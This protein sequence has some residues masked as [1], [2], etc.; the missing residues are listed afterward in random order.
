MVW[1]LIETVSKCDREWGF[2]FSLIDISQI[3]NACLLSNYSCNSK[4]VSTPHCK[5]ALRYSISSVYLVETLLGFLSQ[6]SLANS[7]R[8]A[9]PERSVEVPWHWN[10]IKTCV[11]RG[12]K[13]KW[14][15][16]R[17]TLK[18]H[19]IGS[20]AHPVFHQVT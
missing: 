9:H 13:C 12:S 20:S 17:R 10:C 16:Q 5:M 18:S 3:P 15:G 11:L 8:P 7:L 19:L 2:L 14:L 6:M 4:H 1:F